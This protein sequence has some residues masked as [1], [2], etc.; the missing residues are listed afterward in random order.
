MGI[1]SGKRLT[2]SVIA[3]ASVG[4]LAY[5]GW[6]VINKRKEDTIS[7]SIWDLVKYPFFTFACG[8][9]AGHFFWQRVDKNGNRGNRS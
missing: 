5:E 3:I 9:L 1:R 4:L 2:K 8:I 7:E 6:T